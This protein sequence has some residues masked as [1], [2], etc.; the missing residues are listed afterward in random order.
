MVAL[1]AATPPV[2]GFTGTVKPMIMGIGSTSFAPETMSAYRYADGI[3]GYPSGYAGMQVDFADDGYPWVSNSYVL[4]DLTNVASL[5]GAIVSKTMS[6]S[7][8]VHQVLYFTFI[9]SG[10]SSTIYI[11]MGIAPDT[12][13]SLAATLQPLMTGI[14]NGLAGHAP[15]E[16]GIN[17]DI[18]SAK[19]RYYVT[20]PAA[21][22]D[23]VSATNQI[24]LN[25]SYK[26]A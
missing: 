19:F 7:H 13:H 4:G 8:L 23:T 11:N 5:S 26:R 15:V 20:A 1:P 18:P 14:A 21:G 25:V 16:I 10:S 22:W 3:T 9:A 24:Y 17:Y 2:T 6:V 12:I